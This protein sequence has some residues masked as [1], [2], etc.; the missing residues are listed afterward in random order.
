VAA[1][2]GQLYVRF[3]FSVLALLEIASLSFPRFLKSQGLR[4][5]VFGFAWFLITTLPFTIFAD[6]LFMRY[7][8]LGHAGLA[9]CVGGL[10]ESVVG[11]I[12]ARRAVLPPATAPSHA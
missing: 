6:R 7:G 3:L 2:A 4:V 9:L 10:V 8:Y 12:S 5:V 11:L 1:L